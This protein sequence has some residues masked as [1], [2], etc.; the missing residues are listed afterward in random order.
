VKEVLPRAVLP[1]AVLARAVL[2]RLVGTVAPAP[3]PSTLP[4]RAPSPGTP[5]AVTKH[6]QPWGRAAMACSDHLLPSGSWK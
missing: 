3:S 2:A 6:R 4:G 1:R 5:A